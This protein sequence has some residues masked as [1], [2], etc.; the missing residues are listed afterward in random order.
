MK[1]LILSHTEH[2]T[3]TDGDIVGWGPT[4]SEINFLATQSTHVYHMAFYFNDEAPPSALPYTQKNITFIPLKPVGG[5]G[6]LDKLKIVYQAPK[7]LW[8]VHKA[9]QKVDA[10]QLRTPT[11]IGVFLIPWF[12]LVVRKKGWYKYA[13]NWKQ[14]PAPLGYSLQRFFLKKQRRIVTINGMWPKQLSHCLSFE[15]P[16][17][18]EEER[19]LGS[20]II[21]AKN[22]NKEAF[23]FCFV[24]RLEDA[25]GV[26]R[27]LDAIALLP[28]KKILNE[29]HFI[30]NGPQHQDYKKQC[31]A[32]KIPATFHGFLARDAVFE[33]YKKSEFLVLPSTASEGFPKVIAE[34]MNFG[35]I[36]IVSNV[37]SIG[38]YINTKNGFVL[39]DV[40][41]EKLAEVFQEATNSSELVLKA[42]ADQGYLTAKLFTFQRYCDR[43]YSE[44]LHEPL[45][46]K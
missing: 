28:N 24:G 17:L 45:K 1:L 21:D 32:L 15:N 13:G 2:Y 16:C 23:T 20:K 29:I 36:P 41:P 4:I 10:F 30:G 34:A 25:K 26:Q 14:D 3:N 35:C 42:K 27:I 40:S 6:I 9:L 31:E 46:N 19:K 38:H 7:I 37:S 8:K 43:I 11:G 22:Y 44:I 5:K 39:K 12:T 18:I 33:I